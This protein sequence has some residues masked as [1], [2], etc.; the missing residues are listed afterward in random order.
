MTKNILVLGGAGFIGRHLVR[1]LDA[2]GCRIRVLTRSGRT[3]A[4][5]SSHFDNIELVYGDFMDEHI[6]Q[7]ALTDIDAVYH[8]ITTTFPSTSIHS[9]IYDIQSNLIPTVRLLEL[10]QKESVKRVIYLS[11]GGTV[12]GEPEALPITEDTPL[13]PISIYGQSK[14]V[15]ESYLNFFRDSSGLSIDIL[16]AS[17]PFGPEQNPYGVQGLVSAAIS[18]LLSGRSLPVIGDGSSIRDYLYIDDLIDAL[19]LAL[20]APANLTVNISSEKGTSVMELI[21]LLENVSGRKIKHHYVPNREDFVQ[22]SSLSNA[23][24]AKIM[25]WRPKVSLKDGLRRT[26]VA[27]L[28]DLK[29]LE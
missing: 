15:V 11:S 21:A 1:R 3:V 24:A 28:K 27:A 22:N 19:I 17:N 23:K 13:N 4:S 12:Y 7:T 2:Q 25:N 14:K 29:E 26:W 6:V 10:C 5:L 16:R 9:S 20:E 18:H 8:L